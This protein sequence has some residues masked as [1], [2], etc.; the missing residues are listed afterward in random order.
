MVKP[1]SLDY[2]PELC[3][4]CKANWT[5]MRQCLSEGFKSENFWNAVS[6]IDGSGL[7]STGC[8][9]CQAQFRKEKIEAQNFSRKEKVRGDYYK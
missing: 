3:P 7:F 6:L 8:S 4:Q 9:S 2:E 5:V 1:T